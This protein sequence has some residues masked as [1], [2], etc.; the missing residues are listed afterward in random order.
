MKRIYLNADFECS[1]SEK[2]DTVQSV[3][4]DFFDGKCKAFIEGYRFVPAGTQWARSDGTVFTGEM[5][6]PFKDH[7]MLEMVQA[8]YEQLYQDIT[9]TQLA[10]AELYE[11]EVATG[12]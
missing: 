1:V 2:E 8:L 10:V 7:K 12:D 4:T 5:I 9:E 11:M 3:E 6:A